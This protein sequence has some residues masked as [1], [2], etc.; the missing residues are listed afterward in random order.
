MLPFAAVRRCSMLQC[1]TVCCGVTWSSN[2]AVKIRVAASCC[3][4]QYVVVCCSM[5]QFDLDLKLGDNS[6]E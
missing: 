3:L 4:L 1:A 6:L 2:W 5:L